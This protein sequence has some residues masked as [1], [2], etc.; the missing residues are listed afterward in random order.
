MEKDKPTVLFLIDA[1]ASVAGGI[2]TVN[3][4]LCIA[5]GHLSIGAQGNAFNVVCLANDLTLL[6]SRPLKLRACS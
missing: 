6:N 5:L 2:Q 3:R 1:W 4:Q